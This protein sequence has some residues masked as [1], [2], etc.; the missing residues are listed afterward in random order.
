[1]VRTKGIVTM[2]DEMEIVIYDNEMH[3]EQVIRLWTETFGYAA[4]YNA[5]DV[6]IA[7]K[8]AHDDLLYVALESGQVVGT[9]MA[10]YDGHRGWIYSMAVRHDE[11]KQGVGT[12]LLNHALHRLEELGC[13][14]VNLQVIEGNDAALA[15]YEANGF[16]VEKRISMGKRLGKD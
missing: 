6:V 8:I 4:S 14:K 9:I 10:G 1:M 11:R 2:E 3:R 13:R 12:S 16:A 15:F 7:E 5:P